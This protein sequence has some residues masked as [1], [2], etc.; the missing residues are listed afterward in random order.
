MMGSVVTSALVNAIGGKGNVVMTQGALG[1]SGAQG[2][3]K[4]F[5]QVSTA[6][7]TS[8]CSTNSPPT[9]T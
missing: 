4:G 3:A 6:T 8:S 5:H 7:P 9:G 1:H 2:R